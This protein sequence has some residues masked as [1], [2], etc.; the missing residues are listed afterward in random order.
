MFLEDSQLDVCVRPTVFHPS[1]H[2]FQLVFLECQLRAVDVPDDGSG[3]DGLTLHGLECQNGT[4]HLGRY[5][6][7]G[8]FKDTER[9]V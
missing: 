5:Y 3:F 6:Y 8:G 2:C 9:I 7:F 4:R 1:K